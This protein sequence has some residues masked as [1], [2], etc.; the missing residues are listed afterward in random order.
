MVGTHH[1]Y[2]TLKDRM[3]KNQKSRAI[4]ANHELIHTQLLA[5]PCTKGEKNGHM[6]SAYSDQTPLQKFQ[7]LYMEMLNLDVQI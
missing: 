6:T 7:K 5:L 3:F 4:I 2:L 1:G